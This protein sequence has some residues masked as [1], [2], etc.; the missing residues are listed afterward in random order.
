MS[1]LP[2][3]VAR[4]VGWLR[5]WRSPPDDVKEPCTDCRRRTDRGEGLH[6]ASQ[7]PPHLVDGKCH[8]YIPPENG[9]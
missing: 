9:R 8:D 3:D 4:C 5:H 1:A 6:V 7:W 2:N